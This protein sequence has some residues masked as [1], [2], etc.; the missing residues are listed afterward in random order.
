MKF[1]DSPLKRASVF[2]DRYG[3]RIPILMAP[4]AGASPPA[5]AAA[6]ANAGGMGGCGALLMEPEQIAQWT[7]AF[8]RQSNGGLQLNLWIPDPEPVRDVAHEA[9]VRRFLGKWGPEVPENAGDTA[10]LDFDAQ[11]RALLDARPTVISSIMGLY[12]PN[13]ISEMKRRN[14]AWFATATTVAEAIAAEAAGA[15][16]VIAQG[17]EAGGH[18]GAF[19]A[20]EASHTIAGLFSLLPAVV[21][22]VDVPVVAAGGI[23]DGRGVAAALLLGASAVLVGTG[24]LR[25][26]EAGIPSSWA[27]GIG[28]AQ[29]EDT[30]LTRSFSGRLARALRTAYVRAAAAPDAPEPAPYPIQ[31]ALTRLMRDAGAK[32]NDL[33]RLQ[34]WAGQSGRLAL[35]WPAGEIVTEMWDSA[36]A[37]LA[38]GAR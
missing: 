34:A 2:C 26:P 29:P 38:K 14:I 20:E 24:L 23:A 22:A 28:R 19:E 9:E 25:A 32:S 31:R 3:L 33:D 18:R 15:D 16:V 4:M 1:P 7:Q 6:V 21:D 12:P 30:T 27:D 10:P 37:L 35:A 5:L 8:R 36:E 11:C 13:M 17:M